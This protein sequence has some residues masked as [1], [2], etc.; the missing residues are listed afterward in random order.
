MLVAFALT[1]LLL[2]LLTHG[3]VI[4]ASAATDRATQTP[5]RAHATATREKSPTAT[6]RSATGKFDLALSI[7][8]QRVSPGDTITVTVKATVAGTS[9]PLAN[10]VCALGGSGS[11]P[12]LLTPWPA[13]QT[14]D[15]QGIATWHITVPRVA[16]GTYAIEVKASTATPLYSAYRIGM[17]FVTG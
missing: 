7:S 13:P 5:T 9:T 3:L 17:V 8:P 12:D 11:G 14:T 4:S 6:P 15:T 10:L 1:G 16:A 2:G